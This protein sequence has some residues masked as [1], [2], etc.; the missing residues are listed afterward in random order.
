MFFFGICGDNTCPI[1]LAGMENSQDLFSIKKGSHLKFSPTF[2]TISS[3]GKVLTPTSLAI[4]MKP[5]FVT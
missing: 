1:N 4:T 5:C 2:C 3:S